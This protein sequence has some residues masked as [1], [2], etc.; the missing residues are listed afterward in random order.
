M[1]AH[2]Y[3]SKAANYYIC[4]HCQSWYEQPL[5]RIV[6]KI[7]PKSGHVNHLFKTQFGPTVS[8]KCPECESTLHVSD[9]S[10]VYDSFIITSDRLLVPCG[11]DLYM[12]L[13]LLVAYS[14]ICSR[15]RIIMG[16]L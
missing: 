10:C 2:E 8:E 7:H 13:P 11:P 5:G 14:N 16:R 9:S 4:S 6:D 15:I 1:L 3:F 12:I